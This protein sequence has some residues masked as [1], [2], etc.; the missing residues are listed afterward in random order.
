[1]PTRTAT[2]NVLTQIVIEADSRNLTHPA[3]GW[4]TSAGIFH[5]ETERRERK[6]SRICTAADA[7]RTAFGLG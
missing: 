2:P 1:V 3:P 7:Y 4:P 5:R 6:V